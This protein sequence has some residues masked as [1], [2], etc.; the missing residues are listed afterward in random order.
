[1]AVV[2]LVLRTDWN[3]RPPTPKRF[4]DSRDLPPSRLTPNWNLDTL[5]AAKSMQEKQVVCIP[6]ICCH[7]TSVLRLKIHSK[8]VLEVNKMCHLDRLRG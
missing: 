7:R 8:V 2:Q 6:S 4:M 3:G 1:M 5:I